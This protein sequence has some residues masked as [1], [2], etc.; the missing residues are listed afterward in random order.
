[1][2]KYFPGGTLAPEEVIETETLNSEFRTGVS[3]INRLDRENFGKNIIDDTKMVAEACNSFYTYY[4]EGPTVY[5]STVVSP[6]W[7]IIPA[8]THTITTEEG[9]MRGCFTGTIEK[10]PYYGATAQY[11]NPYRLGIY[12]DGT[13]VAETEQIWQHIF[14]HNISWA[15]PAMPGAHRIEIAVNLQIHL[16]T[17]D[18]AD[19]KDIFNIHDTLTWVRILKR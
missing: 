14:G 17:R 12:V 15:L 4:V 18:G 11:D 6:G 3:I 10:Y 1:M 16:P 19:A 2:T 8:L 9:F 7:W 5:N 13:L